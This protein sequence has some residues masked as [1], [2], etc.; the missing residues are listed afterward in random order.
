MRKRVRT[1]AHAV[2]AL[3]PCRLLIN[4]ILLHVANHEYVQL[5]ED[6]CVCVC[7]CVRNVCVCVCVCV[8]HSCSEGSSFRHLRCRGVWHLHPTTLNEAVDASGKQDLISLVYLPS[9]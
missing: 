1:Q 6:V 3:A 9:D 2:H 8:G 7:V 4:I 5:V